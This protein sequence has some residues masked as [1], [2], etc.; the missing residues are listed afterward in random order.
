MERGKLLG[1]CAIFAGLLLLGLAGL[2]AYWFGAVDMPVRQ[3]PASPALSSYY[4]RR[5]ASGPVRGLIAWWKFDE[6]E[7]SIAYDS[8]GGH[9]G[10]VHGAEHTKGMLDGALHFDGVD[11]YVSIPDSPAFS[12]TKFSLVLW[13]K[14]RDSSTI[15]ELIHTYADHWF[16][17]YGRDEI[18][19]GKINFVMD[20]GTVARL[21]SRTPHDSDQWVHIVAV[22]DCPRAY[23][24]VNGYLE[25]SMELDTCQVI[26]G[27]NLEIGGWS[28]GRQTVDGSIDDVRIYDR[29]LSAEEVR[30]LY[31][32]AH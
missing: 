5:P 9:H 32:K 6:T 30:Q 1:F 23:L 3:P 27:A 13:A 26:D 14:Y 29:A 18:N 7:G 8:A 4:S 19:G 12:V 22:R 25:N 10:T 11:D 17:L 2:A 16:G 31:Q 24:Y 21:R 28:A 15:V 20:D